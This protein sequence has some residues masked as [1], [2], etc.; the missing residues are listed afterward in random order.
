VA[1]ASA[2]TLGR[3]RPDANKSADISSGNNTRR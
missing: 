1:I 2:G 3:P